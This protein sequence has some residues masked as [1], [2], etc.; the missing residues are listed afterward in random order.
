[1]ALSPAK[2]YENAWKWVVTLLL[3]IVVWRFGMYGVDWKSRTSVAAILVAIGVLAFC[4]T[5][6]KR[7]KQT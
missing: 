1:M 5:F 3:I 2:R 7:K 6:W 4:V